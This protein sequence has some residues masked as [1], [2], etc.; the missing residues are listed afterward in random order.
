MLS[1][2][3]TSHNDSDKGLLCSTFI[4]D[5][6]KEEK[7]NRTHLH[8]LLIKHVLHLRHIMCI[9]PKSSLHLRETTNKPN[10]F[11]QLLSPNFLF[12]TLPA[13]PW[14]TMKK[15]KKIRNDS[16]H[17]RLFAFFL[18]FISYQFS[19]TTILPLSFLYILI[20]YF[21]KCH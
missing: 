20:F 9:H 2:C 10:L 7:K 1:R 8:F 11:P 18:Y 17:K 6:N 5:G 21:A 15:K 12:L 16:M 3:I 4:S 14:F 13:N 19:M